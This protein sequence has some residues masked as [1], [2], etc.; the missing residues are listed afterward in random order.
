MIRT[1]VVLREIGFGGFS[2]RTR[3][4]SGRFCFRR[5]RLPE[6]TFSPSQAAH[7]HLLGIKSRCAGTVAY[8][9][10]FILSAETN[11]QFILIILA[12]AFSRQSCRSLHENATP[13]GGSDSSILTEP[14][15]ENQG[16]TLAQVSGAGVGNSNWIPHLD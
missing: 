1:V 13:T 9:L 7:S 8:D 3:H 14:S 10:S 6:M 2:S 12:V 5:A 11:R 15:L 4:Y 16:T